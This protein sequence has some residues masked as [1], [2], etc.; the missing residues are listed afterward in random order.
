MTTVPR[1]RPLARQSETTRSQSIV[2][3]MSRLNAPERVWI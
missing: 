1:L 2:D 3:D